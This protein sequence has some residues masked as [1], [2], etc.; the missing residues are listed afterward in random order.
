[1]K[2]YVDIDNT[3]TKTNGCDYQNCEPI[4]QYIEKINKLYDN[5]NYIVYWTARGVGSGKNYM[6]LTKQQLD[7]WG[8]KYNELRC[9][10]PVY[11]VFVDDK[12]INSIELL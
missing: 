9:D 2:I 1:M 8:C 10:K 6:D 12:T 11:D 3:I 4:A 7:S 5:G